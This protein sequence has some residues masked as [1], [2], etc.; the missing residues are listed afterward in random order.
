LRLLIKSISGLHAIVITDRD[1]V[2]LVKANEELAPELAMRPTFLATTALTTDQ[3]GKLGAGRCKTVVCEYENYQVVH[4]NK[5]PFMVTLIAGNKANTGMLL[6]L[7]N[8]FDPVLNEL[9][10]VIEV[11]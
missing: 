4:F 2:P 3:A 1:G 10:K 6:A 5:Q 9:H 7:E 8:Q 11:P